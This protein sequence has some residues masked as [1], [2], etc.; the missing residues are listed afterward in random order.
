MKSYATLLLVVFA[1][2]S[3]ACHAQ[4]TAPEKADALTPNRSVDD[5][6]ISSYKPPTQGERFK[7][8]LSRTFGIAS[9]LEA[10]VRGGIQQARNNP[11]QWPQGAEVYGDRCGSSMGQI[12]ARG[13]AELVVADFFKEDIRFIPRR[14]RSK[15]KAA[16]EDTF[17]ARKGEDG[18]NAFSVARLIGP[19]AGSAIAISAGIPPDMEARTSPGRRPSVVVFGLRVT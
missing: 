3:L 7:P 11:S 17:L 14:S 6:A 12:A 18:H 16:L 13:A 2:P 15:F 5:P 19:A 10:G 9:M 4:Q 8:Y 1:L